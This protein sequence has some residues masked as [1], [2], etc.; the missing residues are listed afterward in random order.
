MEFSA[1]C[2]DTLSG[3]T[4]SD[5]DRKKF[6]ECWSKTEV[7]RQ[8][9]QLLYTFGD[10]KLPYLFASEHSRLKDRTVIRTGVVFIQ[11]PHIVLPWH[12]SGPEFKEG[13]EHTDA[14]PADAA[15]LLRMMGLPYSQITNRPVAQERIEYGALQAVID[16]LN[17]E[18]EQHQDTDTGLI[19]GVLEGADVALMRYSLT[20]A[21]RSAPEN[22]KE[23]FEHLRRQRNEPIRPD[24]RITDEDIEKLFG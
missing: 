17:R 5:F 9:Q 8:Y 7:I 16:R 10:M 6:K 23:F 3:N 1:L 18:L 13:F 2:K 24:E 20:L 21:I 12:T 11:R 19:K 14:M 4:M 15:Y 22:V